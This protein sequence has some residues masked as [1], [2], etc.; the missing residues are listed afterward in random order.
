M[1]LNQNK[2]MPY[3]FYV[4]MTIGVIGMIYDLTSDNPWRP[5]PLQVEVTLKIEK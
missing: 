1:K 2:L 5:R 3:I 4:S